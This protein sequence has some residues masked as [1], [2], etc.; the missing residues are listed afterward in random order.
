MTEIVGS[1]P[2]RPL[3]DSK[4]TL[5]FVWQPEAGNCQ[6]SNLYS[7]NQFNYPYGG[8]AVWILSDHSENMPASRTT[9]KKATTPAPGSLDQ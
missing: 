3:S 6:P 5:F 8:L 2:Y 7:G 9:A 4:Y 1:R